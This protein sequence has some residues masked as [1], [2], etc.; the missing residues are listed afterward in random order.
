MTPVT[1]GV[2]ARVVYK[3]PERQREYYRNYYAKNKKAI[4]AATSRYKKRNP[5][6]VKGWHYKSLFGISFE[7]YKALGDCCWICGSKEKLCL[8][9]CH[10]T[11]R[12]RGIL[13]RN[14]NIGLG[15]M[16][17]SVANLRKAI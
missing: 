9:H 13:C 2:E 4:H 14:C 7:E 3:D 17:D 10:S 5:D 8:D 1:S 6:K 16:Q 11:G 15:H 12:H